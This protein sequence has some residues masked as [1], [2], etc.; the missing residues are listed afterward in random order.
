MALTVA[1]APE[2]IWMSR[3]AHVDVPLEAL[4]HLLAGAVAQDLGQPT[5]I[6]TVSVA[7]GIEA[8]EW[9]GAQFVP[10]AVVWVLPVTADDLRDLIPKVILTI[11][12]GRV[13]VVHLDDPLHLPDPARFDPGM[14]FDRIVYVT[15]GVPAV[16]APALE[17]LLEPSVLGASGPYFSAVIPSVLVTPEPTFLPWT[18][19]LGAAGASPFRVHRMPDEVDLSGPSAASAERLFRDACTLALDPEALSAKWRAWDLSGRPTAFVDAVP[20]ADK[21]RAQRWGRAVTNRRVGVAVSGGGASAYRVTA[22]LEALDGRGVPVDVLAGLSGGALVGAYYCHGGFDGLRHAAAMGPLFQVALPV[23]LVTSWPM[24]LLIDLDLGFRR[25]EDLDVRF[26]PLTTE[27]PPFGPPRSTVVVEGTI[28]E[29]VRASGCLPPA[30]APMQRHGNRYTDGG[31]ASLVPARIVRDCGAD[32]VVACNVIAGAA[33]SNP[34]DA[35][36][37]LGALLHDWTPIGR[38]I[39]VWTWYTFMWARASRR[40][41]EEADVFVEFEPQDIPFVECFLW[42]MADEIAD[43]ARKDVTLGAS[44][45]EAKAKWDTLHNP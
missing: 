44:A 31:A 36:P 38:L 37:V 15:D 19:L 42:A 29:G 40:F 11:W 16:L 30:F 25:V 9:N 4:T 32:L 22:L 13:F 41:G 28:G 12:R 35:I 45:G 20:S 34:L 21:K 39:D 23:V 2:L 3:A 5:V 8:V 18:W 43:R 6:V 26:V 24:E 10:K 33:R 14:L 1:P 7:R 17:A 27:L